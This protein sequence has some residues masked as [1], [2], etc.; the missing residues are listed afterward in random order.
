MVSMSFQASVMLPAARCP[1]SNVV[2]LDSLGVAGNV[3][4][5]LEPH[6]SRTPKRVTVLQGDA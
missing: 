3:A 6:F 2:Y 4:P 1:F 5:A